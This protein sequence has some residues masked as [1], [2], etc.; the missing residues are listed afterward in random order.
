MM[1]RSRLKWSVAAT[2]LGLAMLLL[3]SADRAIGFSYFQW[4]G[5][6]VAWPGGQ[7]ERWL[8]PSTFPPNETTEPTLSFLAA[9][10]N[11]NEVPKSVFEYFYVF[12][13]QDFPIDNF[14]GF[15]DTAAVPANQ[16][17][18][19]VLGA[20]Y[21]VNDGPSWFDM[22]ML[23]SDLPSGV[24]WHFDAN[25]TCDM[26]ANP[27]P[28][29]GYN[30]L[31]VAMHECGHSL[32]L[33]HDPI[34]NETPGSPWFIQTMNPRYPSGGT[35]G[36]DNVIEL[37]TDDRNGARFLYPHSGPA[38][39]P[40]IDLAS[41]NFTSGPQIGKAIPLFFSPDELAPGDELT[42][43]CVI[44]NLGTSN[45]FDVRQGFYLSVDPVI[46]ASDLLIGDALWDLAFEDAIEFEAEIDLPDD[47]PSGTVYVGSILDDLEQFDEVWEDN[48]AVVYC[49]ALE[50]EQLSPSVEPIPQ[51]IVQADGPF[52]GPTPAVTRPL[53]MSPLTW[54]L[55]N[56]QPGMTINATT[57]VITWPV[58]VASQFQYVLI[59]RAT[60]AAGS[61][62]EFFFLG[63]RP[64]CPAD[65]VPAGG[66]DDIV[67]ISDVVGAVTAFGTSADQFDISPYN[68]G[69]SWGDGQVTVAD[70]TA[71]L[72][73]FGACP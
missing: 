42:M 16:L 19:G 27:L 57:G 41:A 45:I 5:I 12:A 4:G 6:N 71:V 47:L 9:M 13:D 8:S 55:D 35:N 17:D 29:N 67:S 1:K 31:L 56:P 11:W 15:S 33:G 50:I 28:E 2:V 58:P 70:I 40:H 54:S 72:A 32:G 68:G 22:D 43:R 3:A 14:D 63:V 46:D 24:G 20:T 38:Q 66:G 61:D 21:L 53:N 34:G 51:A 69:V 65:C 37:H 62:T 44:Q 10:G 48:N 60:N 59:V 39:P 23:F 49:Q 25:P 64:A 26:L 36:Q 52:T 30:F 7:S 73:A 18:P